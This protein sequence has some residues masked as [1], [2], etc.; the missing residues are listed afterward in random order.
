M[1]LIPNAGDAWKFLSLRWSLV[2]AAVASATYYVF[3][4][5]EPDAQAQI[6]NFLGVPITLLP[7]VRFVIDVYTRLRAQP[8]LHADPYAD[9]PADPPFED[10]RPGL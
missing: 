7:F 4:Q 1:N 9:P 6:L 8:D 5:Q 3:L 10:T 2:A